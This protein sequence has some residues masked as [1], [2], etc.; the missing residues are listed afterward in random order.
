MQSKMHHLVNSLGFSLFINFVILL[1]AVLIGVETFHTSTLIHGIQQ[2]TLVVFTVEIIVRYI[3]KESVKEYFSNGWNIFDIC[4]V[5]ISFIPESLLEGSAALSV[6]RILRVLRVLRLVKVFPELK[7]IVSVLLRSLRSLGYTFGLLSIF[8]YMYAVMGVTLFKGGSL[9]TG[10]EVGPKNPD[11]FGTISEAFFTLFRIMTGEDWTDLRYNLLG[12]G[13]SDFIVTS[14]HVSWMGI[15]AFLLINL[16]VGAVVN[17]YDQVMS[18]YHKDEE[19]D[20]KFRRD[21]H[22]D[23]EI[24]RLHTKIDLLLEEINSLKKR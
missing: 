12:N 15:S 4:I 5:S 13:I 11:P 3:G 17:N 24:I 18:E 16:V 20:N 7:V 19:I 22:R 14:Y 23:E 9:A 8:M 10:N 21:E 1:N 6:F 2:S